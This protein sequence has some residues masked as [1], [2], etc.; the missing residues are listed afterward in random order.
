VCI[1]A[2]PQTGAQVAHGVRDPPPVG[3]SSFGYEAEHYDVS[4]KIGSDR[5]FPATEA[6]DGDRAA[7]HP[8]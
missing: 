8:R 2:Q 3:H 4:V 1:L 5:L 7:D 6:A